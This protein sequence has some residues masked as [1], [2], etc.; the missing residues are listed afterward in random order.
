L[1]LE[2]PDVSQHL[3]GPLAR[4]AA[5]KTA[6][7]RHVPDELGG[8]HVEGEAV[9]FRQVS[10]VLPEFGAVFCDVE[11]HHLR[12]ARGRFEEPE[13]NLDQGALTGAVGADQADNPG[14]ECEIDIVERPDRRVV[15]R[16]ASDLYEHPGFLSG[17]AVVTLDPPTA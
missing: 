11:P 17:A 10:D 7:L 16:E 14:L 15:L 9:V 8:V 12:A 4:R 13:E 2:Q 3:G 6:H 1:G 5:W